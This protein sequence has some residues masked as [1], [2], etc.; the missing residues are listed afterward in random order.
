MVVV[1]VVVVVVE[2]AAEEEEEEEVVVLRRHHFWGGDYS[3]HPTPR[4]SPSLWAR[5][6]NVLRRSGVLPSNRMA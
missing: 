4:L 6:G 5:T 1:V 2:V 3:L